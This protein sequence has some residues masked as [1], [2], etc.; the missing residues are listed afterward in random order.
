MLTAT[1]PKGDRDIADDGPDIR[2]GFATAVSPLVDDLLAADTRAVSAGLAAKG[3]TEPTGEPILRSRYVDPGFAALEMRHIWMRCWQF[4]CREEDIAEV[5]DR[6]AYDVGELSFL[7]VRTAA[8]DF[9]AFYNTCLHRG[10]RLCQGKAS[11]A[12]IRCP[13]HGWNWTLDGALAHVPSHWDFPQVTAATHGLRRVS[14]GRWGGFIFINPDPSAP[15]LADALG[16]LPAHF[17]PA[18]PE[19]R[20]TA[21]HVRKKIRANWKTVIE[22]FLEAYHVIETHRQALSFT[23]DASTQYEIWDDGCSHVSRLITPS[24]VPSPHF[25]DTASARGAA[26]DALAAFATT[27]PPEMAP[28]PGP[29]PAW[30]G[31]KSPS[32]GETPLVRRLR[33]I[34]R[35]RQTRR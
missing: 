33:V 26:A 27:V 5:G 20:F 32:G 30:A 31:R 1:Q 8:D 4:A 28:D 23:G 12:S 16:V 35:R 17:A 15:P 2:R 22:A 11:A 10:T 14:I 7:I 29:I 19:R 34:F 6:V 25:G 3:D 24:A 13:F 9:A 18:S 21:L